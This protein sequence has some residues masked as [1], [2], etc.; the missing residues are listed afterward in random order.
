MPLSSNR[1][2]V[3]QRKLKHMDTPHKFLVLHVS[4]S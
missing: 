3:K 2:N 4:L 1:T